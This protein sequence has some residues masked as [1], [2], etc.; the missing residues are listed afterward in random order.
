MINQKVW[1]IFQTEV[2]DKTRQ[3][4]NE[5]RINILRLVVFIDKHTLDILINPAKEKLNILVDINMNI[6]AGLQGR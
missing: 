1:T 6:A 4:P 5:M 2:A 3:L